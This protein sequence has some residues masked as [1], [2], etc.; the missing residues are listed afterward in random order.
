MRAY[1]FQ[2]P[3]DKDELEYVFE[4]LQEPIEQ[5]RIP[6]VL[7]SPDPALGYDNR[8]FIDDELL[9]KHLIS[10]GIRLDGGKRVA[11]VIPDEM[12]WYSS[13]L[14]VIRDETG[15]YP[16]LIQTED[17]R[18]TIG[19]PGSIRILDPRG[20]EAIL[21]SLRAND[22]QPMNYQF[23][24]DEEKAESNSIKH[25]VSF[26]EASTVFD[27][28]LARIFDDELHSTSEKRK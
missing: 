17:Q 11:L 12:H 13:I 18:N 3:L 14:K 7:P 25:G 10:A 26:D 27:D 2:R 23:E 6:Y 22:K 8:P 20:P 21:N 15:F 1:Y 5:V 24:W 28:S 16:Y 19:N 9:N 4:A